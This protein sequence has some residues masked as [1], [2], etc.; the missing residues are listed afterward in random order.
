MIVTS[1]LRMDLLQPE[2]PRIVHAVQ[3][4]QYTRNLELELYAGD[5]V[6]TVP[7]GADALIRYSK[8]DNR[9]GE[10]NLLPDG[11]AAWS[12]DGHIL[13]VALAPQVLTT[14]GA[15]TLDVVL[16]LGDQQI[17]IFHIVIDV[18]PAVLSDI[19]DSRDYFNVTADIII[20]ALGYTPVDRAGLSIGI[21][22]DGLLYLFID[23]SPT[24]MG[25]AIT[26]DPTAILDTAILDTAIL[27]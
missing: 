18:S 16:S 3:G 8:S 27:A 1:K 14:P 26:G 15:V 7:E 4:D 20:R 9:G 13:T 5:D 22:E 17:S 10:Y 24:G 21:H 6:W 25:I 2:Q 12:A 19:A 11:S 23:G